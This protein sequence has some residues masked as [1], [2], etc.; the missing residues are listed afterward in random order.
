[1]KMIGLV[2]FSI[3]TA[4]VYGEESPRPVLSSEMIKNTKSYSKAKDFCMKQGGKN[5]KGNKL[6]ECIVKYQKE[7]K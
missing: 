4:F 7:A 5:L 6:T 2:F 3:L 1:M